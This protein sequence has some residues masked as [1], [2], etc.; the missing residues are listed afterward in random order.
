MHAFNHQLIDAQ[1]D[2]KFVFW[3]SM[4]RL[5]HRVVKEQLGAQINGRCKG[6]TSYPPLKEFC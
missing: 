4:N 2:E 5:V 1:S 6:A 3:S